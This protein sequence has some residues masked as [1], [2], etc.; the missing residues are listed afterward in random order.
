MMILTNVMELLKIQ[1]RMVIC[2][3]FIMLKMEIYIII[4][5]KIL[6]KL[7]GK[8]KLIHFIMFH[9]GKV[10]NIFIIPQF[11]LINFITTVIFYFCHYLYYFFDFSL[12]NINVSIDRL[13]IN[14]PLITYN[15]YYLY[16]RIKINK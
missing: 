5:Q 2:W 16:Y 15:Y 13:M 7:L 11:L 12:I 8:I 9:K 1:M 10:F 14:H 6:K 3:Y 4:Y